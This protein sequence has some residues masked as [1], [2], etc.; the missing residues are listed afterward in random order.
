MRKLLIVATILFTG[1]SIQNAN[2]IYG[3]SP[4]LGNEVVV[5]LT[6]D[7]LDTDAM[8]S[9][10]LIAPRIVVT[11]AH[12]IN[13]PAESFWVSAPG[14]DL[15]DLNLTKIQG[16]SVF[17]S[18]NFSR[19]KFPYVD[20]IAVILLKNSFP[21]VKP[22]RFAA[23]DEISK[24]ISEESDV[25]HIG[26]GRYELVDE[27]QSGLT[28][29]TSKTPYLLETKFSNK[30]PFQF[31]MLKSGTFSVTKMTIDK[32]VCGGDSGSPLIKRV[33]SDWV[34]IGVQSGGNG[35]GCIAPCPEICVANQF[36]ASANI[37]LFSNVRS[38]LTEDTSKSLNKPKT[39]T[40]I[41]GKTVKIISNSNPKCP[42]GFKKK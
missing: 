4:A 37:D 31:E 39:I 24:W 34:Y 16:K 20:D 40:C 23:V 42:S 28:L 9:G 17:I 32:T 18:K 30:V 21:K 33:G 3:G 2:A 7:R 25:I 22:L 8:C 11:A 36:L 5:A 27:K 38:Y 6:K 29:V 41:K 10:G 14:A 35:A 1:L 26:Y 12:C 15:E 13:G 19:E